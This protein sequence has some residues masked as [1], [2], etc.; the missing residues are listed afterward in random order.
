MSWTA[1]RPGATGCLQGTLPEFRKSGA[2]LWGHSF[3][4][5]P[6]AT[7]TLAEERP[8]GLWL[9]AIVHTT[10]QRKMRAGLSESGLSAADDGAVH[11]LTV[12]DS[13]FQDNGVRLLKALTLYE[14]SVVLLP[15]N[16]GAL[17]TSAKLGRLRLAAHHERRAVWVDAMKI[18][19]SDRCL[20]RG[21][22]ADVTENRCNVQV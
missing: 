14:V 18:P 12:E 7:V 17:V 6:V 2:I 9:E 5:L 22:R 21:S 3:D 1:I 4:S 19:R 20:D 13:D 15:A 8:E 16:A 10:R 11:W